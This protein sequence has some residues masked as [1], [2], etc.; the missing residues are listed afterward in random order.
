MTD[1]Q[2]K[3]YFAIKPSY[4]LVKDLIGFIS[5]W[6][7]TIGTASEG[8]AA[9]WHRNIRFYYSTMMYGSGADSS[10][11]FIGEQGELVKMIVPHARA[12]VEQ[13]LSITTKQKLNFTPEAETS[14]SATVSDTRVAKALC[15]QIVRKENLDAS[16]YRMAEQSA[17]IGAGYL[18][19]S[20]SLDKGKKVGVDPE[21]GRVIYSGDNEIINLT[22]FDVMTDMAIEDFYKQYYAVA[23]V[24]KNRWDLIAQHPHLEQELRAVPAIMKQ[25]DYGA[26]WHHHYTED[27]VFVYEF[28]HRSSPAL[29]DGRMTV[30]CDEKTI[31]YDDAN[32]YRD[33]DGEAFIPIVE[34]KPAGIADTGFGYP[35]FSNI[36]PMQEIMDVC[37][38]AAATNNAA[39][40]VQTVINPIGNQVTVTDIGGMKFVNYM[41]LGD[42]GGGKPEALNLT[43]TAPE[44]YKLI[45]MLRSYMMEIMNI[46][47]ALRGTPPPGVTSGTA[48]ATL[49]TNAIEFTQIFTKAYAMA[50]ERALTYSV[51]NTANFA[52]E[53]MVVSMVGPNKSS[54]AR[55]FLGHELKPI[56]RVVCRLSNPL[57]STAAGKFEIASQ[58]LDKGQIKDPETYWRILE[59]AP[60]EDLY[61]PQYNQQELI[62]RENDMLKNG[63]MPLVLITDNHAKHILK[64]LCLVDDPEVRANGAL[65]AAALQHVQE[66]VAKAREQVMDPILFS[67]VQTGQLPPPQMMMAGPPGL[68]P[69]APP[70]EG[71]G[72]VEPIGPQVAQPAEP[73]ET[74]APQIFSPN[75]MITPPSMGA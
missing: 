67:I 32:P 31:M 51:W 9:I 54:I 42:G 69:G 29:P 65:T 61:E 16:G 21:T 55:E 5:R 71:G 30:F 23:R 66:H 37:F 6:Q 34:M 46:N 18:K 17:I 43:K 58:L 73:A 50:M 56:K 62:Q 10:L 59:G 63:E 64:H 2:T 13:F 22:S 12:L 60:I 36:L 3:E 19:P 49:T 27:M 70:Q 74:Q 35:F 47:G 1:T 53:K 38:S 15:D 14:D 11:G 4:E 68:P 26:L 25:S 39:N 28:F 41:P 45:D 8:F 20:W 7:N 57:M 44:T 72:M 40:G 48:I 33:P 24:K 75:E 52:T